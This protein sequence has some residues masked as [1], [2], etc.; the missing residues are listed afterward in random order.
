LRHCTT[1][2]PIAYPAGIRSNAWLGEIVPVFP[3]PRCSGL[4]LPA[5]PTACNR[6]PNVYVDKSMSDRVEAIFL[7]AARKRTKNE[8]AEN[9]PAAGLLSSRATHRLIGLDYGRINSS[10]LAFIIWAENGF[11]R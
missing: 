2:K 3:L 1:A 8:P 5:R 7:D 6:V 9:F 10:T 4:P 11:C